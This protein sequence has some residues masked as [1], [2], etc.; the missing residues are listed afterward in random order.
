MIRHSPC[1]ITCVTPKDNPESLGDW[2]YFFGYYD[3]CPWNTRG[4]RMLAHRAGFVDRF[5]APADVCE[6]GVLDPSERAF[7]PLASTRAWNWQQGSQLQWINW[8]GDEGD[9]RI[10]FNSR[11][12][13]DH[14]ETTIVRPDGR[15]RVTLD[16]PTYTVS[17][18]GRTMLTL[19]YERLSHCRPEYGYAGLVDPH[20]TNPAPRHSGVQRVDLSTG[21]SEILV[22]IGELAAHRPNPMGE[23]R[24]HHVNH[25]MFNPSGDRFCFMHRFERADGITHSR[26][27]T[28]GT[29]GTGL[30]LL[31]EGLVS[32]YDWV[33]DRTILAW[34][35]RRK[36]LGGGAGGG[37]AGGGGAGGGATGAAM[38]LARRTL[39][40]IYYA[41]GKPRWM[42]SRIVG[43]SYMLIPDTEGAEASVFARG[44]LSTDGHCTVA[45][46]GAGAGRFVLT[47]GYPDGSSRQPLFLY[48]QINRIAHEI[49]RFPTPRGLDG[50]TR[51]DL[52]PRLD[53]TG[54]RVCIDSAM[55]GRRRM[56]VVD[57]SS[58]VGAGPCA[59]GARA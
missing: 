38:T 7:T 32:H 40:P 37:G 18:D 41:M 42:M 56:Y 45:R 25:L 6:V 33:D 4:T 9:E 48:D 21:R 8:L 24:V 10:L 35:G 2:H 59:E 15:D 19:A 26:L 11:R 36:I 3:K 52:H 22:S 13:D 28:L 47:D 51:V 27:F 20:Q 53:R 12:D 44:D 55:D 30:R 57:V 34:A 50:P 49:G 14:I 46:N 31:F 54:T 16:H 17:P 43:D 1:P 58:V 29:D 39:K 23:G 5:P